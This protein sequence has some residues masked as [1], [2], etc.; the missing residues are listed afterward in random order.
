MTLSGV[1]PVGS[2]MSVA[3]IVAHTEFSDRLTASEKHFNENAHAQQ[4]TKQ[5]KHLGW[6][7]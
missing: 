7:S 4:L 2:L 3:V 6:H 1:S 5:W